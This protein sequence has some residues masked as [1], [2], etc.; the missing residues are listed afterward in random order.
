MSAPTLGRAGATSTAS[1]P[2][3]RLPASAARGGW[4]V[5]T[6]L[7]TLTMAKG[8]DKVRGGEA[9]VHE[10][11]EATAVTFTIFIL[12]TASFAEIGDRG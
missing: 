8:T 10:I 3:S 11:A 1:F 2:L 9:E 7:E 12:T 6:T 4:R 5:Q